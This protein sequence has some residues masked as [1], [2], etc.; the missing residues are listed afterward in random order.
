MEEV[1]T[2][3][4]YIKKDPHTCEYIYQLPPKK[5]MVCNNSCRK[6]YLINDVLHYRCGF[7]NPIKMNK[8]T[9]Y[10]KVK[11]HLTKSS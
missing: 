8:D 10:R 1:K 9:E 11:Y 7:H 5:N 6:T 3:R 4:K 2:K